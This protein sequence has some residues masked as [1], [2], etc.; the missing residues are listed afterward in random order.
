MQH[1]VLTVHLRWLA[2]STIRVHS[3]R[4]SSCIY[5]EIPPRDE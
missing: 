5:S 3:D 4:A 1:M 2:A